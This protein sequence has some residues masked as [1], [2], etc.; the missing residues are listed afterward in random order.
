MDQTENHLTACFQYGD[1]IH[2]LVGKIGYLCTR[3]GHIF[4]IFHIVFKHFF[5]LFS[6]AFHLKISRT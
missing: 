1:S 4:S 2:H 6:E 5:T 3:V